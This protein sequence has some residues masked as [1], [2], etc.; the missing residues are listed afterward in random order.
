MKYLMLIAMIFM[1]TPA[2]ADECVTTKMAFDQ[3]TA[4]FPTATFEMVNVSDNQKVIDWVTTFKKFKTEGTATIYIARYPH[5]FAGPLVGIGL[6]DK[7]GCI[8]QGLNTPEGVWKD[9]GVKSV[10]IP[11]S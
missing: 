11:T 4:R 6:F 5:P 2:F 8:I 3:V 1:V 7:N 9:L 10:P